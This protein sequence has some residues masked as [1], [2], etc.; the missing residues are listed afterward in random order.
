MDKYIVKVTAA[1]IRKGQGYVRKHKKILDP[2][3]TKNCAVAL[4]F[5]RVTGD[6]NAVWRFAHGDTINGNYKAI[7]AE[8]VDKWVEKHDSLKTV[9][10]FNFTVVVDN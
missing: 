9:K 2:S 7:R 5:Q 3:L 6:P 4:A 8:F 1:D 10:P